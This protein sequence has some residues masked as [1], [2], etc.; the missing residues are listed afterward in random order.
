MCFTSLSPWWE[1]NYWTLSQIGIL[2]VMMDTI[3][4]FLSLNVH[5]KYYRF[6]CGGCDS[7]LKRCCVKLTD[8]MTRKKELELAEMHRDDGPKE[9]NT[10][11]DATA[12]RQNSGQMVTAAG[13][14][15][16]DEAASI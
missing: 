7:R 5:D 8:R 1:H 4:V 12:E 13:S 10:G 3:C 11:G 2:D 14:E 9:S 16:V 6:C 15:T